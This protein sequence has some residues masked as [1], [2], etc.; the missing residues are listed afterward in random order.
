MGD[1]LY[2]PRGYPHVTESD[3]QQASLHLTFTAQVLAQR[4]S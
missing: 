4:A 2:V 3:P 1:I